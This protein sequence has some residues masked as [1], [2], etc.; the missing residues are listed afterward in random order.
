MRAVALTLLAVAGAFGFIYT[1]IYDVSATRPHWPI[2]YW[3]MDTVRVHS[4][5]LRAAGITP[6]AT[7]K[8]GTK[9]SLTRRVH[10]S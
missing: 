1:G 2:T 5:R 4:V 3:V 10:C 7:A 8:L 9:I 6:V